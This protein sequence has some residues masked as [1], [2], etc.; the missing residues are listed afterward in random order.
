MT[1]TAELLSRLRSRDIRLWL[2]EDRLKCSAPPHALDAELRAAMVSCKLELVALLREAAVLKQLPKAIV[3]IKAVGRRPPLFALPGHN[4]DVFCYRA[5]ARHLHPDQPLLGVQ[6][7]G[8]DGGR[9]LG[10]VEALA[11]YQVEQIRRAQPQG[12]YRIAGY[13]AGGSIAFEVAQQLREAGQEV[14]L[15]ALL[16]SPFPLTFRHGPR[17]RIVLAGLPLR[18]T[19]HAAALR[20]LTWVDVLRTPARIAGRLV[21][22]PLPAG[23]DPEVIAARKRVEAATLAALRN[24]RPR[25]YPHRLDLFV[26][27]AAWRPHGALPH[28]WRSVAAALREHKSPV[29]TDAEFVLLEPRVTLLAAS[30]QARL[31]E[32]GR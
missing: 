31:D 25:S 17:L 18:L 29:D 7:P 5:L 9:P 16:G 19:R 1:A 26:P 6:P 21:R 14:A 32:L 23:V 20:S 27:S 3:P 8:L 15:L 4:G 30:L 10:Q 11:R 2:E 22:A 28:Q 24:Y 13:C 12:P